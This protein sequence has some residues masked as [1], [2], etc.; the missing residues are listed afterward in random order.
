M[1]DSLGLEQ[2]SPS[3]WNTHFVD[4]PLSVEAKVGRDPLKFN[5]NFR[6]ALLSPEKYTTNSQT[7]GH[8]E[9]VALVVCAKTVS[10]TPHRFINVCNCKLRPTVGDS[11]PAFDTW[12]SM[13]K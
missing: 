2:K 9:F 11:S 3:E 10:A 12:E 7:A 4:Q 1:S 6:P 5:M 13:T 8:L